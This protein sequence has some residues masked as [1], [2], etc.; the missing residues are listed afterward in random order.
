MR[1]SSRSILDAEWDAEWDAE[2]DAELGAEWARWTQTSARP[3]EE[4][5]RAAR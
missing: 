4:A 1:A 2:R 5:N 3:A